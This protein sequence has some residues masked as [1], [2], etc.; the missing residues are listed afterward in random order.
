MRLLLIRHG[1]TNANVNRQ[2]DTAHPGNPLDDRGL[3]Q[4]AELVETLAG[5]RIDAI[6]AS[7]LTRAQQTA[8]PLAAARGL[9]VQVIDGVQEIAAG[10]EELNTD[11]TAYVGMLNSWS[12]TNLDAKLDGGESARE[13]L[14][15]FNGAVAAIEA[16]GHEVAALVTHGAAMRVWAV[17]QDPS[18]PLDVA[19]PLHNT[20]WIELVG[21]GAEGWRI[22]LWGGLAADGNAPAAPGAS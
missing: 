9:D 11:W 7:T 6:Y 15:R 21:S 13:F 16:A 10:V 3:E 1:Q 20:R 12:P 22:E 2:L 14:T 19:Q 4:A 18:F 5:Y 17:A 8:A